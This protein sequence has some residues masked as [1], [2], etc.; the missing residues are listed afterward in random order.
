MWTTIE[1]LMEGATEAAEESA[2]PGTGLALA[3]SC[4][5]RR[6]VLGPRTEEE[7]ECV[8]D[9]LGGQTPLVGFYSYGEI[10]PVEGKCALHNQT[11]TVTTLHERD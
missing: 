9:A 3:V 7:I 5:G 8:G 6:L 2:Q 1:D 11:M 4:V 10:T